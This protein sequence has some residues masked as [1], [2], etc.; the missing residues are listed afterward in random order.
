MGGRSIP[1]THC[2]MHVAQRMHETQ[3]FL[4]QVSLQDIMIIIGRQSLQVNDRKT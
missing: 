1:I 3:H 4:K 2:F